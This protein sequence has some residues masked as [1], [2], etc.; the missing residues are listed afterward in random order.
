MNSNANLSGDH[1]GNVLTICKGTTMEIWSTQSFNAFPTTLIRDVSNLCLSKLP[2]KL[3]YKYFILFLHLCIFLF[4]DHCK[5]FYF[6]ADFLP[7]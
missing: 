7:R 5:F 6:V 2:C 1:C 4:F 3:Y